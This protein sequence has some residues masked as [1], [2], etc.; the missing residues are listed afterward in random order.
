M[1]KHPALTQKRVEKILADGVTRRR[2]YREYFPVALSAYPAPGRIGFH[3]AIHGTYQPIKVGHRFGPPWSTHWVNVVV[4]VPKGWKG[5]EVH[6]L[7][8]AC[9]EACVWESGKVRQGLTGSLHRHS[10]GAGDHP[11][12]PEYVLT[13]QAKGGET[14]HLYI[15]VACNHLFGVDTNTSMPGVLK[16]AEI[17]VFDRAAWDL[18]FDFLTV[19]EMMQ[20]LSLDSPRGAQAL[21]AANA[22]INAYHP[23]DRPT[24]ASA[25]KI[26]RDYLKARSGGGQHRISAIG[27]AHIDTAWL[28]PLAETRRKCYRSFSSVLRVMEEYAEFKFACSQAQHYAWIKEG[29]P[30]LYSEI[31]RRISEGRFIPVGGTWI[32]PDCN[33]P[34][35]ESLV[36][37]FL[38]G[39]RFFKNEFGFYCNGFW[40]PD[41]FGYNAQLPQLIRGAG[42][43]WFLTQKLSWN[44]M[45]RPDAHT[46]WWEGLDGSRVLTH[47]P[48]TDTYNG[49]VSVR[50]LLFHVRNYKDLERSNES[51][52]L[53]GFGDGGGG[54]T[55]EMME[56]IRRARDTD[57]L[58]KVTIQIGR[59]H[60]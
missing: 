10:D 56:R 29:Q 37:Q 4:R 58:P 3:E 40:N 5:A 44:Q 13:R 43:T 30:E 54:P 28:W 47:F 49:S 51:G 45:N 18:H 60:V 19:A 20:H 25:H 2:M 48:P 22:F 38:F 9:T 35:G 12:R 16:R 34:S 32:E 6:L 57:G 26:L 42:M 39:Q 15:E 23:E 21:Y 17:A 1:Q 24:W 46:F 14:F 50:E 53:F 33:L 27:H 36:R 55:R 31:R 59:A 41:V 7:W 11:I 8:D 52:Y